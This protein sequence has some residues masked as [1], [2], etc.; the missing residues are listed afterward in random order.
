M[1]ENL[2]PKEGPVIAKEKEVVYN[3][4][5][6]YCEKKHDSTP[7]TLCASCQDLLRYSHHRLDHCTYGELKPTCRKCE[8]HCYRPEMRERIRRVMRFSGPRLLLRAPLDW[9]RHQLHDRD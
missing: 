9:I 1:S 3:M 8:K 4:I 7:G 6:L 2:E 5:H